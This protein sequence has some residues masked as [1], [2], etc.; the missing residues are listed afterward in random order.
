MIP[1]AQISQSSALRYRFEMLR[2]GEVVATLP[3]VDH[4]IT[5]AGLEALASQY[6]PDMI[7]QP[8]LGDA[9]SPTP[10]RRDGGSILF[11]QAAD[12]V[13]TDGSV[14]FF[15]AADVGR[16]LKFGAGTDGA[17]CYVSEFISASSV[18]VDRSA[19]V[20]SQPAVIWYVNTAAILSPIAGLSWAAVNGSAYN[21]TQGTVSGDVA[22]ITHQTTRLSSAFSTAKTI[23]EI[24]FTSGG[25]NTNVFDR[26]TIQPGAGVLIGD[27]ARV[28]IQLIYKVSGVTPVAVAD[29]GTGVNA[30]G[31]AALVSAGLDFQF[32][33]FSGFNPD[34]T[35]YTG[36]AVLDPCSTRGGI[37]LISADFTLPG[38]SLASPGNLTG[39]NADV[40][41]VPYVSGSLI[42][43][44]IANYATAAANGMI[45][46]FSLTASGKDIYILKLATPFVKANAQTL[47]ITFRKSFRRLLNN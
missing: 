31:T 30:A 42:H 29:F 23:T 4:M 15:T 22:T 37:K 8:I 20:T 9:A 13:S 6:G 16:L 41:A 2:G 5:D 34:G 35:T 33:G 26:D 24:A 45:Y 12:V 14:A 19:T 18:R 32:N 17:E 43:D 39:A 7:V 40:A 46:G 38:F 1:T 11:S 25:V 21:Y 10:V 27:Q 28:T 47:A 36:S 44:Y 3:W